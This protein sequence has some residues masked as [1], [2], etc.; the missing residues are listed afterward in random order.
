MEIRRLVIRWGVYH[1]TKKIE[2]LIFKRLAILGNIVVCITLFVSLKGWRYRIIRPR[3]NN[4]CP[5][6]CPLHAALCVDVSLA[7][8]SFS[9]SS[10]IPDLFIE[11]LFRDATSFRVRWIL[12]R[13][14]VRRTFTILCLYFA[15]W[16]WYL[17]FQVEFAV[18]EWFGVAMSCDRRK[19]VRF[20][21]WKWS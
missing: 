18:D 4:R 5:D 19:I 11:R 10:S 2:D 14:L 15:W 6:F 16:K 3:S 13:I 20:S 1:Q 7:C 9:L 12:S 17:M 8:S 21:L